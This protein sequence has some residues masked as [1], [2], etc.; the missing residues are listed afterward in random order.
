MDDFCWGGSKIFRQ[1]VIENIKSTFVIKSEEVTKFK[2]VGLDIEQKEEEIMISEDKYVETLKAIPYFVSSE[3]MDRQN[4]IDKTV[5]RQVNGKLNWIAT[6]TRPD[7]SFDVSEFSSFMKRGNVECFK[8]A[9]KNIKK[10]KREKSQICI[11]NLGDLEKLNIV[12][13]SHA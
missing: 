13:Y 9:N 6:Q 11:P 7:L 3:R 5:V 8:K 10:A 4:P 12:A 2:Y 1:S